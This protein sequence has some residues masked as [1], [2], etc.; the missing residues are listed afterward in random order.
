MP[1]FSGVD[2]VTLS[3]AIL[4]GMAAAQDS[5]HFRTLRA[6]AIKSYSPDFQSPTDIPIDAH[7]PIDEPAE[8]WRDVFERE[9]IRG[10][11][12]TALLHF[13]KAEEAL[14]SLAKGALAKQEEE[15]NLKE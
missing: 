4:D 12:K 15:M 2:R 9:N 11:M 10:L 3:P 1:P 14:Y 6:R 13:G 5:D 7:F 8:L